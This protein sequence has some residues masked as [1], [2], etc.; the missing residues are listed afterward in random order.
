MA[1]LR[2]CAPLAVAAKGR[3]ETLREGPCR[4]PTIGCPPRRG[5]G[6]Q[7]MA[8]RRRSGQRLCC[9][10]GRRSLAAARA[11]LAQPVLVAA[12]PAAER[13]ASAAQEEGELYEPNRLGIAFYM[14]H[15][16]SII[17]GAV[18]RSSAGLTAP[19][20]G[21]DAGH[22]GRALCRPARPRRHA[23]HDRL[24]PAPLPL[25]HVPHPHLYTLYRDCQKVCMCTC[26]G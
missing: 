14:L 25:S 23:L 15:M 1:P 26:T 21:L 16:V 6:G 10:D 11:P 18:W 20:L 22:C 4:R 12:W 5:L 9:G 17:V 7:P 24:R 8:A 2:C 19:P 13:M 3:C